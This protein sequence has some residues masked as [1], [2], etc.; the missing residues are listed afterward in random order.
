MVPDKTLNCPTGV[1]R[2]VPTKL[3]NLRKALAL[4]N[5]RRSKFA[6]E[7]VKERQSLKHVSLAL[8]FKTYLQSEALKATPLTLQ[9]FL[10]AEEKMRSWGP[11]TRSTNWGNAI[12]MIRRGEVFGLPS[13]D[14]M[15]NQLFKDARHTVK[16]LGNRHQPTKPA[17][18]TPSQLHQVIMRLSDIEMHR[19]AVLST[20]LGSRISDVLQLEIPN[21]EIV[22]KIA[23][24]ALSVHFTA[25]KVVDQIGPYTVGTKMGI[26]AM[27]IRKWLKEPQLFRPRTERQ[28]DAFEARFLN[29]LKKLCP[30]MGLRSFRNS[31]AVTMAH[32]FA[33]MEELQQFL[34]HASPVNTLKYLR[35]GRDFFHGL[36]VGYRSMQRSESEGRDFSN[37]F[38]EAEGMKRLDASCIASEASKFQR[39]KTQSSMKKHG[40]LKHLLGL[41]S[42]TSTP[43]LCE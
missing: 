3:V 26:Y 41:T 36:R 25:G 39:K 5:S 40:E 13:F 14:P 7:A 22:E 17:L 43:R 29:S 24:D 11:G 34:R 31:F 18:L 8:R 37:Y 32:Q 12:G 1:T 9:E 42:G 33:T 23:K 38:G 16:V 19:A 15:Q 4:A 30:K 2:R 35:E 28:R 6:A 10:V 21:L 27:L 20:I